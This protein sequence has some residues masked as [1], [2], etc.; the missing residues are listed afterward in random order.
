MVW[1]NGLQ[2]DA[3][4]NLLV[5]AVQSVF[6][7][8]R[9][10]YEINRNTN[11]HT[12]PVMS[13]P[14]TETLL[15][16]MPVGY[17]PYLLQSSAGTPTGIAGITGGDPVNFT[18]GYRVQVASRI[19]GGNV[20][21]TTD[22]TVFRL[23]FIVDSLAP[24]FLML[25]NPNPVRFLVR[26]SLG[27]QYVETT[28]VTP[29][30]AGYGNF[31]QLTF[32]SRAVRE[33]WV[34]SFGS[35]AMFSVGVLPNESVKPA[36]VGIRATILGDS[37]DAGTL[38]G[39]NTNQGD[40]IFNVMA[41]A[42]GIYD[43]RFSGI[44]S[45]GILAASTQYNLIQRLSPANNAVAFVTDAPPSDVFIICMGTNDTTFTY[46]QLVA[47]MAQCIQLLLSQ[48]PTT[49]IIVIGCPPGKP[50]PNEAVT[51]VDVAYA[52][53][54]AQFSPSQVVFIPNA[55]RTP[56]PPVWGAGAVTIPQAGTLT[57]TATIAAATTCTLTAGFPGLTGGYQINF[58]DG[59]QKWINITNGTTTL[60]WT[61]AV[62]A[63]ATILYS[64][65]FGSLVFT[66]TVPAG[67]TSATLTAGFSNHGL[68]STAYV[69]FSSGE[70]RLV[71]L[72]GGSTACAWTDP[73]L[74]P[75]STLARWNDSTTYSGPSDIYFTTSSGAHPNSAGAFAFGID[76]A[77]TL[78][79]ALKGL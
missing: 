46:A 70:I 18:A 31:I 32:G 38:T 33:I 69:T 62:T 44:A 13:S 48:Y 9:S 41:D 53:A 28:G 71:T 5:N 40:G 14:P 54:C 68:N 23:K 74:L 60:T 79:A 50:G 1:Q 16:A 57:A 65:M 77:D 63:S 35:A 21:T 37:L 34:E 20:S 24:V 22:A 11:P 58:S 30:N 72:T 55:T 75:A 43:A 12:L 27:M 59:T 42:F 26:T 64:G 8:L 15:A 17:Q 67:A 52:A 61:G 2:F 29:S 36:E 39:S 4:G 51:T 3:S 66:A 6:A 47:G 7:R 76:Y 19:S 56:Y 78:Y 73:L 49:P 10:G 25:N 45:T